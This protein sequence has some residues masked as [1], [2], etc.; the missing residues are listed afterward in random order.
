M[1]SSDLK[2][3]KSLQEK[4]TSMRTS[5]SASLEVTFGGYSCQGAKAENQDAFALKINQGQSL[6][7]KGHIA[8]IADGVSSANQAAKASQMS[9]CHFIDE[10]L[11]TPDTWSVHKSAT[12]VIASLNNW[13]FSQQVVSDTKGELQQWFSTF[14]AVILKGNRC[15]LFHIGDCQVAKVNDD[16]YQVLTRE[17]ATSGG[18]LNRAL[19]AVTHIE[20]DA[21]TSAM[22]IGDIIML[23][24]DGVYQYVKPKHIRALLKST[25]DLE[26]ASKAITT[27]ASE[28][29]SLDNLTCLLIKVEQL[30]SQQFNDLVFHRKQ[31]VIPPALN[32]GV[33]LDHF[34]V[35]DVL[36]QTARSHVYLAKDNQAQRLVV[37]KM[38]SLNFIDDEEYLAN[39]IKEGW[40]GEKLSHPSIMQIHPWRMRSQFLYHVCEYV[41]G[42]T[43]AAW[44]QENP[45]PSFTKVCAIAEQIVI[46]LR[47][48]QRHDVV[49][50]DIKLDN[51]M[52]DEH[53]RIK[54]IDFGS[55]NVGALADEQNNNQ[56]QPQGT[57]SYSAPELFYGQKSSH[58]S[59]L[60]S[61]AVVVYQLLT[62]RLPYGELSRVEQVPK[63]FSLWR[64][65]PVTSYRNDLPTWLDMVL[66]KGLNA[67]PSMRYQHYSEFIGDLN[68]RN[69]DNVLLQVKRPLIERDPVKFWQGVSAIL[70]VITLLQLFW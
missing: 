53:G 23:S 16:G 38:P 68:N 4:V 50:S 1:G 67:D 10:Y 35:L 20:I 41:E 3:V 58:Q 47:V 48:F 54:L 18:I 66:S 33:S 8:V 2:Q 32:V 64:Y 36:E 49:H 13:L 63:Q 14:S 24:C 7:L 12:K 6:E 39:F 61:V 44:L 42:Q 17:H 70:M 56:H 51:F 34:E 60:F 43:L 19:G 37:L 62:N 27:L 57:I 29:G 15:H 11:A 9:V 52:I 40:L 21:S 45:K 65:R 46:C 59:E 26:Q 55:C 25:T 5:N 28:Q 30:P 22:A 69:Q 31:Q